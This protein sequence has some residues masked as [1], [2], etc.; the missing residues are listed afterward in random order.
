MV[1]K[2]GSNMELNNSTDGASCAAQITEIILAR[3]GIG[4]LRFTTV[5][6]I[7]EKIFGRGVTQNPVWTFCVFGQVG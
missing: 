7:H 3:N 2:V 5:C 4:K 6:K 1:C